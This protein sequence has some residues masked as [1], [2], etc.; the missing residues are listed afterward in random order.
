MKKLYIVP[1]V[2]E[3]NVE[4]R[5]IRH[6]ISTDSP[7]RDGDTIN[8]MGWDLSEWKENP[9]VLFAHR[10]DMPPIANGIIKQIPNGL[11]AVSKFPPIGVFPFADT[12]FSLNELGLLRTWSVGFSGI[13]SKFRMDDEDSIIGIEFQKQKLLEYSSVAVPANTEAVNLAV[14][15]GLVTVEALDI[16]GWNKTQTHKEPPKSQSL[17]VIV[18][19]TFEQSSKQI[20]SDL[21]CQRVERAFRDAIGIRRKGKPN[22]L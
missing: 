14:S 18:A 11:E 4:K 22:E 12:V 1:E 7:D 21:Q 15:K 2:K 20:A 10:H 8:P 3:I 5:T 13:E 9:V 16:L 17:G 19:A 6:I